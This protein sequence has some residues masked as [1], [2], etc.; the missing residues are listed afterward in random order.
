MTEP[1]VAIDIARVSQTYLSE[2]GPISALQD[3]NLTV[4][5]GE[6]V[7]LLGK[8]GCGKSTLL[9]MIG[10]L[11]A[12]SEGK[13]VVDGEA[14]R[15]PTRKIGYVFQTPVLLRWRT[16]I[17]NVLLPVEVF[18]WDTAKYRKRAQELLE[19]V[20]LKG[21]ENKWPHQLSGGMQQ[22][23]A[24][25]RCLIFDPEVLLMD[26]PFGALDAITR[27][28]MNLE[29]LR[30]WE[31]SGKTVIFV[32]HDINEALFLADRVVLMGGRPGTVSIDTQVP[33]KRPRQL[34][35]A[36][37]AECGPLRRQLRQAME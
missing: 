2:N 7:A 19:M 37:G 33:V 1:G 32:T 35:E 36:F 9:K 26:E 22:R 24:L 34:D 13:V 10:G 30:V 5:R 27:E 11:L 12:P 8:S 15:G 25:A 3:V 16:V 4:R 28:Q 20:H 29:L 18:R 31:Q 14:I 23:V 6:F 21:F 17:D